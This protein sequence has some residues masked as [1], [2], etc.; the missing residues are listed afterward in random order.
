MLQSILL[1]VCIWC[2]CSE[3]ESTGLPCVHIASVLKKEIDDWNGFSHHDVSPRYWTLLYSQYAFTSSP[4][5]P[6]LIKII[7]QEPTGPRFQMNCLPTSMTYLPRECVVDVRDQVQNYS[8][9]EIDNL[10]PTSSVQRDLSGHMVIS[11]YHELSQES[12]LLND[13]EESNRE[14]TSF[15]EVWSSHMED[16]FDDSRKDNVVNL[17]EERKMTINEVLSC[18]ESL[19]NKRG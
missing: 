19:E 10:V 6:L 14:D 18:M 5:S 16:E 1:V 8:R 17:R 13:T 15:P 4:L 9:S 11:S 12:Y 7:E 2:S 3:Y